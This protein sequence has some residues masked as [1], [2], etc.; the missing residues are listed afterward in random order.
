MAERND[1]KHSRSSS[2]EDDHDDKNGKNQTVINMGN[3]IRRKKEAEFKKE[4]NI[5][6]TFLV[7]FFWQTFLDFSDFKLNF[8]FS[9]HR[10]I[11]S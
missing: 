3:K 10:M 4:K 5:Q 8:E 2:E 1:K 11:C 9:N 7:L 6:K